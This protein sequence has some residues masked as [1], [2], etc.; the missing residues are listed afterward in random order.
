[1]QHLRMSIICS[2]D[3]RLSRKTESTNDNIRKA[4][5][6]FV[7]SAT[8]HLH[9]WKKSF[10]EL[11]N[12]EPQQGPPSEPQLIKLPQATMRDAEPT[13]DEDRM[14]IR[15]L[16]KWKMP[17]ADQITVYLSSF[18]SQKTFHLSGNVPSAC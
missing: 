17:G 5:G 16:K 10:N 12:H 7:R 14:A 4:D 1:M 3:P 11:Y 13:I 15:S 2:T 6:T 18:G 9:H 8:K